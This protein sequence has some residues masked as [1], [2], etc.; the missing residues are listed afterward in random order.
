MATIY[1]L[2][3]LRAM[4]FVIS[5]YNDMYDFFCLVQSRL[6]D[7]VNGTHNNWVFFRDTFTP[8][9]MTYFNAS[10]HNLNVPYYYYNTAGYF[11]HKYSVTN[12]VHYTLPWLSANIVCDDMVYPMD[13]FL[14]RFSFD[15]DG[16]VPDPRI[17]LSCWSLHSH[18]WFLPSE[19]VKFEIIDEDANSFSIPVF[20]N[21]EKYIEMWDAFFP[22]REED[23]DVVEEADDKNNEVPEVVEGQYANVSEVNEVT[24]VSEIAEGQVAPVSEVAEGQVAPV[25]DVT[26]AQGSSAAEVVL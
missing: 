13:D 4:D 6:T 11:L 24:P 15:A 14:H 26:V 21:E 19:N 10:L 9:N 12:T 20:T 23:C 16:A 17:L 25:K 5:T 22:F 2:Y 3:A 8:V 7:W 18:K 1:I